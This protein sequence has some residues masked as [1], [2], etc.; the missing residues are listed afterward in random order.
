MKQTTILIKLLLWLLV[1]QLPGL[2]SAPFVYGNMEWYRQLAHPLLTPPDALFGIVWGLLYALMGISAFLAFRTKIH[3]KACALLIV[4]L[5]LNGCWTPL[6]F[7]A[8]SLAGG[9][10]LLLL[11]IGMM[12]ALLPAFW[13][14]NKTS[15][16]L[17]LPYSIW[18]LFAAY[19][20]AGHWWMN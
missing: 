20:T 9:F 7:G 2:L 17:L 16:V 8:H 14:I 4:Q 6:F 18:L 13:R 1:C 19:L 15:A 10:L 3:A 12:G 5:L 11:M